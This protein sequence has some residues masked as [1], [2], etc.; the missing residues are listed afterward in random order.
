MKMRETARSKRGEIPVSENKCWYCTLQLN[1][2]HTV[3]LSEEWVSIKLPEQCPN[4]DCPYLLAPQR[5]SSR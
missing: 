2:F 4:R 3:Q 5:P 1:I